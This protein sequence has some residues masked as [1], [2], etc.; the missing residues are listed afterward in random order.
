MF[1]YRKNLKN[2]ESAQLCLPVPQYR[3]PHNIFGTPPILPLHVCRATAAWAQTRSLFLGC[4]SKHFFK[5]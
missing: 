2:T 4:S 1:Y 5:K 3:I